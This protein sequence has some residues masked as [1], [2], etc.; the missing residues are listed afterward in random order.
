VDLLHK[1]PRYQ[2]ALLPGRNTKEQEKGQKVSKSTLCRQIFTEIFGPDEQPNVQRIKT[3]IT[4]LVRV[5]THELKK[6]GATGSGLLWDEI[7]HGSEVSGHCEA[8]RLTVLNIV[9]LCSLHQIYQERTNIAKRLPWFERWH[10]MSVDR[11]AATPSRLLLA[12]TNMEYLLNESYSASEA[13]HVQSLNE[14]AIEVSDEPQDDDDDL[15]NNNNNNDDD[16]DEDDI[17]EHGRDL[18]SLEAIA[19]RASSDPFVLSCPTAPQQSTSTPQAT[20]R[21][22][23]DSDEEDPN[24]Q[25]T[26]TSPTQARRSA[27]ITVQN[28]HKQE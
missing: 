8:V 26:S 7:E 10:E 19:A 23:S 2:I 3:K 18:P 1:N 22:R 4:T 11:P 9:T 17:V 13:N 15:N 12:G 27:G 21:R 14:E 16:D 24:C 20:G 5:Y 28:R 25:V 6:L